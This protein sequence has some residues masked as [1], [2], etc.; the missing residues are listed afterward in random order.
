MLMPLKDY[1]QKFEA[2]MA[3]DEALE[4][5]NAQLPKLEEFILPAGTRGAAAPSAARTA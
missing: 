4:R 3:L 2:V 5:Y 1:A